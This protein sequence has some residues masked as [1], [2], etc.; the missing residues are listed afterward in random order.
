MR[1]QKA[2]HARAAQ[3]RCSAQAPSPEALVRTARVGVA[4]AVDSR[5]VAVPY[6]VAADTGS[7]PPG[8]RQTFVAPRL[9]VSDA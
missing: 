1:Y 9:V 2:K 8:G 5:R 7:G 4:A 6:E 3:G